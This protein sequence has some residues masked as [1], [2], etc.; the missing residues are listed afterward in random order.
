[1]EQTCRISQGSEQEAEL[2]G[3]ERLKTGNYVLTKASSLE[4]ILPEHTEV[5][6]K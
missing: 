2:L 1:M 4:E 5:G 6:P 3:P